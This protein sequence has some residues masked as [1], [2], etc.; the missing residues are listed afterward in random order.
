MA[1]LLDMNELID[2]RF[3]T[4]MKYRKNKNNAL[5]LQETSGTFLNLMKKIK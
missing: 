2:I 1:Y 3:A 4:L 5:P